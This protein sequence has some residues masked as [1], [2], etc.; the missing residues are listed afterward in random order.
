LL[1]RADDLDTD[2]TDTSTGSWYIIRA[3]K[4]NWNDAYMVNFRVYEKTIRVSLS[5][6]STPIY[7][8]IL[9]VSIQSLH[10]TNSSLII[11]TYLSEVVYVKD[12]Q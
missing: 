10:D 4:E 9:G 6:M 7:P 12:V 8:F 1:C 3:A 5:F 2:P 11:I